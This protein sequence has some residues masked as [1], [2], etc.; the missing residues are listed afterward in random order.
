MIP[1]S[2]MA[3]FRA[4]PLPPNCIFKDAVPSKSIDLLKKGKI[5]AAAAPVGALPEISDIVEYAGNYG[6]GAKG[7]V[8]SVLLFS[9]IPFNEYS[10]DKKIEI[11]SH[12]ATS[13]KLLY[14]LL[15]YENGFDKIPEFIKDQRLPDGE[16][17]I[18]DK[19][20]IRKHD[21]VQSVKNNYIYD[22]SSLWHEKMN[23]PFVFARWVVRQDAPKEF[24]EALNSWL[25]KIKNNEES[26]IRQCA[27]LEAKRLNIDT[28]AMEKYLKGMKRVIS[29]LYI[30][31]QTTFLQELERFYP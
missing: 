16:L 22:L 2:N 30:E 3:P 26:L 29:P 9:S 24:K 6:I 12:T 23:L 4:S 25:S 31:G 5:L 14:L 8:E 13:V 20:L 28:A 27:P 18:G 21:N 15:G 7:R 19:A 11:T 10:K 1:Y 17:L